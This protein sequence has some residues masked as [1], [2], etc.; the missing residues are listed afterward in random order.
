M[1]ERPVYLIAAREDSASAQSAE[2]L[3]QLAEGP[4]DLLIFDG[5]GHGASLIP[6]HPDLAESLLRWLG[7]NL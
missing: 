3:N 7:A 5:G 4:R 1:G 6:L 2:A